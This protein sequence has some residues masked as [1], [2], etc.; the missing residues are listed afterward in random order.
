MTEEEKIKKIIEN[1]PNWDKRL[2][3]IFQ[4]GKE[5]KKI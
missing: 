2:I 1:E 3:K 5:A 4:E